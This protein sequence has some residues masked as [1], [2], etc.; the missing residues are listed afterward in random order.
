MS[1]EHI[2][3]IDFSMMTNRMMKRDGWTAREVEQGIRLYRNYLILK[4]KY[5]EENLPPSEDIDEV[6][7]N[8]IL[9]TKKYQEDCKKIFG[10]YLEHYP[11][12][13][14]DER[15]N[16]DDLARAFERTQELHV[17]EFGYQ[18]PRIR[19]PF[20]LRWLSGF[21][22]ASKKAAGVQTTFAP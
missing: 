21:N 2:E 8:H 3:S 18:I 20:L 12:F 1:I 6:W 16:M 19:Y 4:S 13:G 22:T 10:R 14:M 15:S 7:H 5:P 17:L 11:Y 9:D